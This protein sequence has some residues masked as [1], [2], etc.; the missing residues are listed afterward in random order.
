MG[1]N[2]YYL[3]HCTRLEFKYL[4]RFQKLYRNQKTVGYFV[5]LWLTIHLQIDGS[6]SAN[7]LEQLRGEREI[8]CKLRETRLF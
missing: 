3:G 2:A 5:P 7:D 4:K 1:N 6:H 8:A